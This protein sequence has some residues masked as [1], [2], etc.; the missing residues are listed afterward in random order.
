[1]DF[2]ADG[3][4][5]AFSLLFSMDEE[6]MNILV[7]TLQLTAVSM[8]VYC[9]SGCLSASFSGTLISPANAASVPW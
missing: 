8:G 1:M 9:S 6:T 7:T 2:I 4:I 5:Q 3:F